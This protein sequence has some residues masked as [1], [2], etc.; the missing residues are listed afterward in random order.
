MLFPFLVSPLKPP[1][2]PPPS[3]FT[4]PFTPTSWPWQ[5]LILGHITFRGPRASSPI[6]DCLGR[7][8]L[9]MQL[10]PWVPPFVFFGWW[11]STWELWG[12]WLVYIFVPPMGQQTPAAPWVLSLAP[13]LGTLCSIQWMSM[14]IHF[15]ICQALA[16]PLRRQ[17]YQAPASKHLLAS[18]IVSRFDNC[19][20]DG[21]PGGAV[22][23]SDSFSHCLTLC[24]C[25]SFHGCFVP[26]LRRTKVSTPWS[27]F[28]SLM[29]FA[30]VYLGYSELLG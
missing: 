13:T 20:W 23:A 27:F 2:S 10:E 15:Y 3:L 4:N 25:N 29:C 9:P 16:E 24:L 30:H 6:D 17:L 28:L 12:Y 5:S 11:F 1:Y 26:L 21:L 18:T 22:S 14:S 8:L 19:I 7:P